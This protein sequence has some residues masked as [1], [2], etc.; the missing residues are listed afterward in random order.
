MGGTSELQ[1]AIENFDMQSFL[2]AEGLDYKIQHG[3]SGEQIN[4]RACPVCGTEKWKVYL[5]SESPNLGNCFSGSCQAKFNTFTFVRAV[6]GTENNREATAYLL[7]SAKEQGWRYKRTVERAVE[8]EETECVLPDSIAL[9]TVD[10]VNLEYLTRRGI[11]D[12]MTRYFHLRYC[13]FG[14]HNFTKSD[15][16]QGGQKFDDRLIIPIFDLDGTLVTFQGRDLSGTSDRKYLFPSG[17]PG[18]GRFLYNGHNAMGA[19]RIALGEGAFDVYGLFSAFQTQAD[20]R[21]V[22]PVGTFGMHLSALDAKEC[23]D[24]LGKLL[25]LKGRGLEEVT[26]VWDGEPKAYLN[27]INAAE[28][29]NKF[30][31]VKVRIAQLPAG[32]DPGEATVPEIVSAFYKAQPYTRILKAQAMIKNPYGKVK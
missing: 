17:L 13:E 27:A 19:K 12:E 21:D 6:L 28:V 20:L 9:P 16:E 25:V 23:N 3:S 4:L 2:D 10:G 31:G 29:I 26:I 7:K 14:W 5:N 30:V 24:Q 18:T 15:G 22:M 11:T 32:R 1:E 8:M